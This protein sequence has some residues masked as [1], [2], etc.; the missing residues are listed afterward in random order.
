MFWA[1]LSRIHLKAIHGFGLLFPQGVVGK[2]YCAFIVAVNRGRG[3]GVTEIPKDGAF[4][5]RNF[6][7]V[8]RRGHF[9]F[10]R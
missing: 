10:H 4:I 7:I 2:T 3:L 8:K 5:V 1:T 6:G 9:S